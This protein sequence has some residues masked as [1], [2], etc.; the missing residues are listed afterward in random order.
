[1]SPKPKILLVDDEERFR[2]TLKKMLTAQGLTVT[3]AAGGQEALDLMR[4]EPYDAALVDIRMPGMDGLQTLAQMK[5][6]DPGMEV[7]MLTGHASVD[8]AMEI[9]RLG[10]FDYLLKPCPLEDLL[11]KIEAAYEKKLD[12]EKRS[13]AAARP[14]A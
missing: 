13:R 8:A 12:R 6:L 4:L 14:E 11:L 2:T 5:K 3:L 10:G 1:M 7:I 9:N